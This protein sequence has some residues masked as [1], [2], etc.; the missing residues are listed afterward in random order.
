[1]SREEMG[2]E[3]VQDKLEE[4][5]FGNFINSFKGKQMLFR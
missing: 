3:F 2:D 4:W 1:V 5:G